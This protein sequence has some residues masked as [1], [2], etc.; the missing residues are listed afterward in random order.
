VE[1]ASELL[2]HIRLENIDDA[3]G[4]SAATHMYRIAQE[5]INNVLKHAQARN[6]WVDAIRD[7]DSVVLRI[8]D[9]G[10]GFAN[11]AAVGAAGLGMLSMRERCNILGATLRID[12]GVSGTRIVV[13][14]PLERESGDA[15]IAAK[16]DPAMKRA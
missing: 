10:R 15:E 8:R 9:D 4:G 5:A 13:R 14:I 2:V 16:P 7:A 11:L 12:S 1:N 6:L 3:I